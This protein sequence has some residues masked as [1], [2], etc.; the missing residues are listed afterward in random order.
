ME[1]TYNYTVTDANACEK[2]QI[3]TITEPTTINLSVSLS[4]ATICACLLYTS[5]CV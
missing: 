1:G 5:R 2:I 4:N 3:L